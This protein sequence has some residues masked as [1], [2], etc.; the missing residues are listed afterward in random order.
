VPY[1]VI[2]K[3]RAFVVPICVLLKLTF[4]LLAAQLIKYKID[5]VTIPDLAEIPE[6]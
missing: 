4:K 1:L 5:G 2:K 6:A 3:G